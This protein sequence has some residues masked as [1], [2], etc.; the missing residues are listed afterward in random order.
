MARTIETIVFGCANFGGFG[1]N[2]KAL[3]KGN[4]EAEAHALL[5]RAYDLG[6]RVY[7]TAN[8]YADGLSETYLGNW[9]RK[10]GPSVRNSVRVTTKVGN[11]FGHEIEER[12]KLRSLRRADILIECDQSLERL[13]VDAIDTYFVHMPNP[14]TPV[15]ETIQAFRE[16]KESG[17]IRHIGASNLDD[18]S[19]AEYTATEAVSVLQ[20]KLNLVERSPLLTECARKGIGFWAYSPL[21]GGVLSGKYKE[22]SPFPDGSRGQILGPEYAKLLDPSVYKRVAEARDASKKLGISLPALGYLWLFDQSA[23]TGVIVGPKRVEHLDALAEALRFGG[24]ISSV[25]S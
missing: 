20:N 24:D 22:G 7:D 17:K 10:R 11:V 21:M 12:R 16:L 13:G 2:L 9:L 23:V 14:D 25:I 4:S 15:S 3:G 8:T 18:K 1:S 6:I 5:D 19:F